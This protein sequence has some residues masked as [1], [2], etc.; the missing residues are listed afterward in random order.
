MVFT[1]LCSDCCTV[2]LVTIP[3]RP[4]PQ[5][6]CALNGSLQPRTP[7][8][9]SVNALAHAVTPDSGILFVKRTSGDQQ[10]GAQSSSTTIPLSPSNST[11]CRTIPT[12]PPV[13]TPSDPPPANLNSISASPS[14]HSTLVCGGTSNVWSSSAS[15]VKI[16]ASA[17]PL[18]AFSVLIVLRQLATSGVFSSVV[19]INLIS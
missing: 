10:T 4:F 15:A 8:F 6:L 11:P 14:N 5:S 1:F 2:Q 19:M 17:S 9:I 12:M 13:C 3:A 7:G 16:S 18:L